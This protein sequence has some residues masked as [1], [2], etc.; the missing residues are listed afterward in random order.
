MR[1][2]HEPGTEAVWREFSPPRKAGNSGYFSTVDRWKRQGLYLAHP[3]SLLYPIL[4]FLM[5]I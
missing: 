2:S 3:A 4:V 5:K 1:Y